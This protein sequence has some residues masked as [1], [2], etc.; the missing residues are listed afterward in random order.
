MANIKILFISIL[1]TSILQATSINDFIDLNKCDKVIDKKVIKICY[2]YKYKG[3]LAV[4]YT[5]DGQKVNNTN[6][7]KRP[8][9]YTEKNLPNKHRSKY[10]DY[11]RSG[12]D[13]GH[14]AP[15]ASFDY[16]K[17]V[18]SKVYTMANI[19]PQYPNLNRNK[20]TKAEK[21]ERYIAAKLGKATIINLVE[22]PS[23]HKRIGKN[24]IAVPS[25]FTKVIYNDTVDFKKCFKY[26]N[27]NT[28]AKG[29]KLKHHLVNCD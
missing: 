12:F 29:D 6:I 16:D 17:K 26:K 5:L 23:N 1:F 18:L 10:K 11:T 19:V 3:A 8:R 7:K 2:S 21:F 27:I 14:L 15:D 20:W 28:K 24:Q 4:W 13:R 9:F 25:S 22:Y